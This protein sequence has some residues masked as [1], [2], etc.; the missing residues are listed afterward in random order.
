MEK[1]E[2]TQY[3]PGMH[4]LPLK[5]LLTGAIPALAL[6]LTGCGEPD[7][8]ADG[9]VALDVWVHSGRAE[10]RETIT[11][12]V[13]RFNAQSRDAV[14]RLTVVPEGGYNGQVQAAALADA[15]P[16]I[17]EFDG[18]YVSN[19]A[20]QG[21]LRPLDDL[22][23]ETLKR[24]LLPSI[25]SQGTYAGR[26]FSVGTFDSGLGLFAR[27]SRLEA[28]GVRI[29]TSPE[30]AW[31]VDEF[32]DILERLA[33]SDPD[34][35]VLDLK[36]NYRGEWYAYAFS[37]L[38]QSAGGDLVSRPD[39]ERA[40]GFLNGPAA[41]AA[42]ER[43]QSWFQNERVD[44]NLDDDAFTGG[45]VALSLVGHWE[46]ERYAEKW[47]NDLVL[48]PLPDF[49][50]GSVSGQGSWNWGISASCRHPEL[51]ARFLAFLLEPEE[52]LK[53]SSANG[54]VPATRTAIERSARYSENGP[55]SLFARQLLEGRTVPRPQTPAYPLISSAFERAFHDIRAGK[56]IRSALGQAAKVIDEDI[57]DNRGYPVVR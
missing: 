24:N 7:R 28:A 49:G 20:W 12:Q 40:D 17:V 44:P 1:S 34:G 15:L 18:P 14:L 41:V 13:A 19:Y 42:M 55:L 35:R 39:F 47:R 11:D 29:P 6:A 4:R 43:I 54:A 31:S 3:A 36:S 57:A 25:I 9:R 33:G 22:L 27:R 50:R 56:D 5:T 16:D 10:E 23:D 21:K 38:I 46:F 26:L 32:D 52:V 8:N 48:L 37:P 51:A 53:I 30:S 45:R 2:E